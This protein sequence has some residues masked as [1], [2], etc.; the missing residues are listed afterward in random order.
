MEYEMHFDACLVI[1]RHLEKIKAPLEVRREWK[2]ILVPL[3]NMAEYGKD[4]D[5]N[6]WWGADLE[7]PNPN[8]PGFFYKQDD[9]GQPINKGLVDLPEELIESVLWEQ[10]FKSALEHCEIEFEALITE[11]CEPFGLKERAEEYVSARQV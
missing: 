5:G 8:G 4:A 11:W 2:R 1:T 9:A 3:R 10:V 7:C 6:E